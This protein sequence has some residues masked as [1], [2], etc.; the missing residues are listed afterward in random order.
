MEDG[1]Y[2]VYKKHSFKADINRRSKIL[3]LY[4]KSQTLPE[5]N[6]NKSNDGY[7]LDVDPSSV[8]DLYSL[9]TYCIVDGDSFEILGKSD[10]GLILFT[11][12]ADLA[13]KHGFF[14]YGRDEFRG[15]V[16]DYQLIQKKRSL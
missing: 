10:T 15:E 6:L 11:F 1:K 13:N 4:S 16:T 9:K 14:P 3:T 5:F 7:A 12:N 2:A 8:E